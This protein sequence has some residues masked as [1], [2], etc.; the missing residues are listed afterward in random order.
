MEN[1]GN[2]SFV[3]HSKWENHPKM[4]DLITR[5]YMRCGVARDWL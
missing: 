4:M 5:G 2:T 1:P 3:W